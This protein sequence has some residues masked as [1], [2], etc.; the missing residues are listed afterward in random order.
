MERCARQSRQNEA[1]IFCHKWICCDIRSGHCEY[2]HT[3]HSNWAQ[4][5]R[6]QNTNSTLWFKRTHISIECESLK[7]L[8]RCTHLEHKVHCAQFQC[9]SSVCWTRRARFGHHEP[10]CAPNHVFCFIHASWQHKVR[11]AIRRTLW[12]GRISKTIA[13]TCK[14]K[15]SKLS[16]CDLALFEDTT[17]TT[18]AQ[19][20]RHP[21]SRENTV[22]TNCEQPSNLPSDFRSH[23]KYYYNGTQGFLKTCRR[24]RAG[25]NFLC[26][27]CV[28]GAR[29]RPNQ[30]PIWTFVSDRTPPNYHRA[31]ECTIASTKKTKH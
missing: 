22:K 12:E 23:C 7:C 3:R 8:T 9:K 24:L 13:K 4:N 19:K 2:K 26:L 17:Q 16:G 25:D 5:L 10:I 18:S 29:D 21:N 27:C 1:S 6:V 28:T 30:S 31:T 20:R 11:H 15:H 14:N